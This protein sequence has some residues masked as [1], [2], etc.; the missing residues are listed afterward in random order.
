VLPALDME[1]AN[2][3]PLLASARYSLIPEAGLVAARDGDGRASLAGAHWLALQA[4][5]EE[6]AQFTQTLRH[7]AQSMVELKPQLR[8]LLHYHCGVAMFRTRQLLL[9]LQT[10]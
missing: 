7:V 2:L 3:A 6:R 5:L 10:L 9:D 1:T 8:A 4:A